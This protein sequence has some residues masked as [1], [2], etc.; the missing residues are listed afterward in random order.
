MADT[1]DMTRVT[2]GLVPE[3]LDP[4]LQAQ[5]AEIIDSHRA[6]PGALIP[7]LHEAQELYGYLPMPVLERISAGLKVPM[8]EVYGVV[9][10]YSR[11]SL[12]PKGKYRIQVCMGTACYVKGAEAL[13]D[14]LREVLRI[15]PG[16]MTADKLFSLDQ[17]RCIGACGLAP[18]L[19]V[20]TEV[21][22]KME[23]T[24]I[25]SL[26]AELRAKEGR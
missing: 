22:A 18:A 3:P 12:Q 21:H 20:N 13:L 24:Q 26:I 7:V 14:R 19:I 5:L 25:D 8:T 2:T 10:F 11:F 4:A 15:D 6:M 23:T 16:Q 9:T 17:C 1:T